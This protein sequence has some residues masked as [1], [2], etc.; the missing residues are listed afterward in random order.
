M[1][2]VEVLRDHLSSGTREVQREGL[3]GASE[4]MKF[5]DEL[6]GQV[7]LIPPDDPSEASVDEPKLMT[8]GVDRLH[9]W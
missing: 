2:Q 9:S 8:A 6:L 7:R 3:L 5:E 4:I 1:N